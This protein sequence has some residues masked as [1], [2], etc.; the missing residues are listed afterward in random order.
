MASMKKINYSC[1]GGIEK[2]VNHDHHFSSLSK[3]R[4][5]KWWSSGRI[6][7]SHPHTHDLTINNN[8]NIILYFPI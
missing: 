6:F 1:E 3:P 5:A 8:N 2:S 4:D 7:L